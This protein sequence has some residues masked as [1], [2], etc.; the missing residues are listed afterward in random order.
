MSRQ[1]VNF[2]FLR[3]F[4]V[5]VIPYNIAYSIDTVSQSHVVG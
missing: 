1:T 2:K 3:K 5:F 4:V